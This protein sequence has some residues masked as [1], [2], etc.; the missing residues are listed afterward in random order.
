MAQR[1]ALENRELVQKVFTVNSPML[2]KETYLKNH[3]N[4]FNFTVDHLVVGGDIVSKVGYKLLPGV[5]YKASGESLASAHNSSVFYDAAF[6]ALKTPVI[7]YDPSK[8]YT[9][10][11]KKINFF[12]NQV[13]KFLNNFPFTQ[14]RSI[15]LKRKIRNFQKSDC[16]LYSS[17]VEGL[18]EGFYHGTGHM[19]SEQFFESK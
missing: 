13:R 2:D 7:V 3:F 12:I 15:F 11:I 9:I 5:V 4:H 6:K 19:K 18:C 10:S 8:N 1:L 17:Q 16:P 14:I